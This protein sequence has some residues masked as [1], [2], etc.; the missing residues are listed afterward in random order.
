MSVLIRLF[1]TTTC[2][3][4]CFAVRLR[5][6]ECNFYETIFFVVYVDVAGFSVMI[7]FNCILDL[8]SLIF[9]NQNKLIKK[10]KFIIL[11]TELSR[12]YVL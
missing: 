10:F 2:M 7:K 3:F 9:V 5:Q 12:V 4:V 11:K 8:T 6:Q 1:V